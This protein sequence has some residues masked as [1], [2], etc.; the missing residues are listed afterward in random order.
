M[1]WSV[2]RTAIPLVITLT[3]GTI[4][5]MTYPGG[6]LA[7]LWLALASAGVA[8]MGGLWG[9]GVMYR[10]QKQSAGGLV[11]VG[12]FIALF[13]SIGTVPLDLM[14]GWLPAVARWNPVTPILTLSR[15]GFVGTNAWSDIWPGLVAIVGSS[16][17]LAWW[18]ARGMRRLNP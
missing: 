4:G 12:L 11:Q 13:L 14:E 15:A 16:V 2:M 3:I 7:V 17:L 6:V 8:V 18:A 1:L 10:A 9:S 5:G